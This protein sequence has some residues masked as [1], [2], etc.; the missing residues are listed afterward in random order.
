MAARMAAALVALLAS[1]LVPAAASGGPTLDSWLHC[2]LAGGPGPAQADPMIQAIESNA[3]FAN[4]SNIQFAWAGTSSA[5][6]ASTYCGPPRLS[7]SGGVGQAQACTIT[8]NPAFW[9]PLTSASMIAHEYF[10]AY[11]DA[12]FCALDV[13]TLNLQSPGSGYGNSPA[14]PFNA[15][16]ILTHYSDYLIY[17]AQL[18]QAIEQGNKAAAIFDANWAV[19]SLLIYDNSRTIVSRTLDTVQR[20]LTQRLSSDR[21]SL[22]GYGASADGTVQ[23]V[24]ASMATGGAA[25]LE[26]QVQVPAAPDGYLMLRYPVDDPRVTAGLAPQLADP[27]GA[28]TNYATPA[29]YTAAIAFLVKK[30]AETQAL[31]GTLPATLTAADVYAAMSGAGYTSGRYDPVQFGNDYFD[32][33]TGALIPGSQLGNAGLVPPGA[34]TGAGCPLPA[35]WTLPGNSQNAA[36]AQSLAPP[37][38][39]RATAIEPVVAPG[40]PYSRIRILSNVTVHDVA[41]VFLL[42][43]NTQALCYVGRAIDPKTVPD[44]AW[45]KWD[46]LATALSGTREEIFENHGYYLEERTH[47]D[48]DNIKVDMG[49]CAVTFGAPGRTIDVV[50]GCSRTHVDYQRKVIEKTF[51]MQA[52]CLYRASRA[53]MAKRMAPRLPQGEEATFA[54]NRCRY[55]MPEYPDL[56]TLPAW[57]AQ[58]YQLTT[59]AMKA[60]FCEFTAMPYWPG[61]NWR[62]VEIAVTQPA[63]ELAR[64]SRYATAAARMHGFS[65]E[66]VATLPTGE[67]LPNQGVVE[68]LPTAIEFNGAPT[69]DHYTMPADAAGFEIRDSEAQIRAQLPSLSINDV[70]NLLAPILS[71]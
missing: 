12:T 50:H 52:S 42:T 34:G 5:S 56:T 57:L 19:S 46:R 15:E 17:L 61:A 47:T 2:V 9:S 8:L 49:S 10:H 54:M 18:R 38:E 23:I 45:V 40:Q 35:N 62:A 63:D 53:A 31:L 6:T 69:L 60:R 11:C 70:D 68:R 20:T 64:A 39:T 71:P 16:E 28:A 13:D 59:G 58:L 55:L 33:K 43:R 44:D 26:I 30:M 51:D 29:D 22:V 7:A 21:D 27:G 36:T 37:P 24:Q 4:G 3:Q 66:A 25:A 41:A 14:A 65:A 67:S 32:P 48:A 1:A